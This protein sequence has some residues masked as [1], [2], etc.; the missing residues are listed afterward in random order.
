LSPQYHWLDEAVGVSYIFAL[1]YWVFA[2]STREA[3][4]REFTPQMQSFLLAA[5][6]SARSARIGIANTS[7]MNSRKDDE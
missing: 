4:R 7:S 6:G 1:S 3:E 5:A 2:F